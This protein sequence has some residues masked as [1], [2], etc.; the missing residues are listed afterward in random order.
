[1]AEAESE[2]ARTLQKTYEGQAAETG[3]L[4]RQLSGAVTEA[5][6]EEPWDNFHARRALNVT[7]EQLLAAQESMLEVPEPRAAAAK[8]RR[9]EVSKSCF[10]SPIRCCFLWNA[11]WSLLVS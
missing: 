11:C 4:L 2:I 1:M 10:A 5:L 3:A 8:K 9:V 7:L 6:K